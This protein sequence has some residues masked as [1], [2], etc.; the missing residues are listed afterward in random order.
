MIGYVIVIVL[1]CVSVSVRGHCHGLSQTDM[2]VDFNFPQIHSFPPFFTRQLHEETWRKQLKLW[3][4]LLLSYATANKIFELDLRSET[5]YLLP[6]F[7]NPQ[8]D[9]RMDPQF[10][11]EIF[12]EIVREGRGSWISSSSSS[13]EKG[14]QQVIL[15][16]WRNPQEWANEIY[17]FVR[18]SGG[19]GTI[20]TIYDLIEG[21][22]TLKEGKFLLFFIVII[23]YHNILSEY[24][25]HIHIRRLS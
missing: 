12:D 4:D 3:I 15:L 14:K 25:Y 2:N 7:Y 8:I 16:Y 13:K 6:L 9:R 22:D 10:L 17:R 18:E 24:L 19:V 5:T 11:S 1:D 21:D 20:Y 23:I